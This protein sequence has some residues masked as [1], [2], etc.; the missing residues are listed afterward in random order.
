MITL[1]SSSPNLY[2]QIELVMQATFAGAIKTSVEWI[3]ESMISLFNNHN[4]YVRPIGGDILSDEMFVSW[5]E[6][7]IG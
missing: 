7:L 4:S 1:F 3:A 2:E 6:P 5:S